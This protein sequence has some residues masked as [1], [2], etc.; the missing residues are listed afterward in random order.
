[1]NRWGPLGSLEHSIVRNSCPG[2]AMGIE[3]NELLVRFLS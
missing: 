3:M 2:A 1:M